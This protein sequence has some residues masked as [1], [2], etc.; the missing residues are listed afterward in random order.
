MP[1]VTI[2]KG[3]D[4]GRT[5]KLDRDET[6]PMTLGRKDAFFTIK[7]PLASRRHIQFI[8]KDGRWYLRDLGSSNGTLVNNHKIDKPVKLHDGDLIQVGASTLLVGKPRQVE[9]AA[10]DAPADDEQSQ[11]QTPTPAPEQEPE[12]EQEAAPVVLSSKRPRH[13]ESSF[14]HPDPED[15][16][17]ASSLLLDVFQEA[18]DDAP[19]PDYVPDYDPLNPRS[20]RHSRQQDIAEDPPAAPDHDSTIQVPQ[21]VIARIAA[22]LG[23]EDD[24]DL[25][26]PRSADE[27]AD[28]EAPAP[29]KRRK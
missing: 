12:Q 19:L 18:T 10:P 21:E 4:K 27:S 29:T 2:I 11:V 6:Q 17:D 20:R 9:S 15:P 5:L 28:L 26:P 3:P 23:D 13:E 24:D 7:D 16:N 1:K 25:V 14:G 8:H 22:E